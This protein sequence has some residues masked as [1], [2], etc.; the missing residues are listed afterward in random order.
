MKLCK[1]C[2]E[3]LDSKPVFT[4]PD[5][6]NAQG[7]V[8]EKGKTPL[9]LELFQ[10]KHCGLVQLACKPVNYYKEVIRATSVSKEMRALRLAQFRRFFKKYKC[11]KTVEIGSGTGDYLEILTEVN[12]NSFGLEAGK[13]N[14]NICQDKG[15]KVFEGY[16]D[17]ENK[18][19]QKAPYDS[20]IMMNFLEHFPRPLTALKAIW[21]NLTD[22]AFGIVEVPNFEETVKENNFLDFVPDHLL[23]FTK[24]TLSLML[25][26]AGFEVIEIRSVFHNYILQAEVKKSVPLSCAAFKS[27][28]IKNKKQIENLLKKFPAKQLAIWG[29]GHQSLSLMS[30][31]GLNDKKIKYVIDSAPF[32]Q[33]KLTPA[34]FIPVVS[35][36]VLL[37]SPPAATLRGVNTYAKPKAIL[38]IAGGYTKEIVKQIKS[39]GLKIQIFTFDKGVLLNES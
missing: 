32:K 5:I 1:L 13:K 33:N 11:K 27:E 34:T 22:N 21:N 2:K 3:N 20:F 17:K 28:V 12:K 30:I 31:C 23:Y 36:A 18:K 15:L 19:I 39:Y 37:F 6:P 25:G 24:D 35:P 9:C 16:L 8:T 38:V 10:C 14:I 7:F 26:L 4:L 29:A